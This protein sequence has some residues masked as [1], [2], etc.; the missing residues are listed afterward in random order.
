M[1]K[2]MRSIEYRS[3]NSFNRTRSM[4]TT[5]KW[6]NFDLKSKIAVTMHVTNTMHMLG[7]ISLDEFF[8]ACNKIIDFFSKCISFLGSWFHAMHILLLNKV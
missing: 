3:A 6:S 5:L 8:S 2:N 1:E 4:L 7:L